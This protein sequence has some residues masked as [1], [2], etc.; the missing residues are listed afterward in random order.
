MRA[1]LL[2][3]LLV[4][5]AGAAVAQTTGNANT[6]APQ[7]DTVGDQGTVGSGQEAGA[8]ASADDG[9]VNHLYWVIPLLVAIPLVLW[10]MNRRRHHHNDVRDVRHDRRV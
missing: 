7:D 5:A 6:D 2:V 8:D 10:A 9:G 3:S 4:L 1:L